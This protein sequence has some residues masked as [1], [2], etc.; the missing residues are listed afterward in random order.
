MAIPGWIED[1]WLTKRPNPETG[2]RERTKLWGKCL[3]YRV[4]G[5]P[6]VRKRSFETKDEAKAWLNETIAAIKKKDFVDEREGEILLGEYITDIWWPKCEY[7]ESTATGMKMRIFKHIVDTSLGQTPMYVIGD[8]HLR[9]W[10]QELAARK[11]M[12]STKVLIWNHLSTILQSAVGKRIS[13]NPCREAEDGIRPKA[14]GNTKARAWTPKEAHALR[15]AL[16]E[17]YRIIADLGMHAG[18]RQAEATAFSPDDIDR[19]RMELHVRR[20]IQ[21]TVGKNPYFKL[22]KG[23]KERVVPLSPGLL[24]R[25][26][27]YQE[28]FPPRAVTLPWKGPGNGDRPTATVRLLTTSHWGN[29]INPNTFNE[30]TMKPALVAAGLIPAPA[31]GERW[32]ASR[33][34]MHHRWRHTYASVQLGAGEDVISVSHWMGHAS[35]VITLDV[36]AHF[37]PDDGQ[38]GRTALDAWLEAG[39]PKPPSSVGLEEVEPLEYTAFAELRL[40]LGADGLPVELTA[41]GARYGGAWAVGLQADPG[42][43]L[44]GEIRTKA[45]GDG[46]RAL[47]AALVFVREYCERNGM[48]VVRAENLSGGFPAAVRPY[49]ALGRFLIASGGD[50]AE[51]SR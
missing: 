22:P 13:R 15:Q 24:K 29:R 45:G 4:C 49:Q 3:R 7:D 5:I 42:G 32:E 40:P 35:P 26:D 31:K 14:E 19:E 18:Q 44:L 25:I 33:E 28:Q 12:D 37:L 36:Y 50:E 46:D 38:K 6:G 9:A 41:T 47:A 51:I 21:W 23:K 27:E 8:S 20:Q 39:V 10:K 16:P 1:R 30:K 11:L 17:R 48:T 34:M 43:E 2:K